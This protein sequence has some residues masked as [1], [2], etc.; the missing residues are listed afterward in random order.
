MNIY[1]NGESQSIETPITI[2]ALVARQSLAQSQIAVEING[3]I[4]PRS[5]YA[6]T[7]VAE[8]DKVEIVRFIGGG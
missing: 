8:G 7:L 6:G 1:I 4:V 3:A 5:T 2:E